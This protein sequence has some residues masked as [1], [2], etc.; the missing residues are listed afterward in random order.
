[1]NSVGMLT[2]TQVFIAVAGTACL[3]IG[4]GTGWSYGLKVAVLPCYWHTYHVL[5]GIALGLTVAWLSRTLYR[6]WYAYRLAADEYLR[7]VLT[8]LYSIDLIWLGIFPGVSE[9]F[10][11]RGVALPSLGMNFTALVITSVVFGALHMSS[12]R[13]LPYTIWAGI[14]G[15]CFGGLTLLT[16]NLLPVII[17][18]SLTNALSGWF[19][20]KAQGEAAS[21]E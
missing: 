14:V 18:H 7:I 12:W 19:W 10:L 2:R 6:Q 15:M 16:H 5:G 17:A 9:E 11:F 20:Q 21:A 13:H 1:M 8:P 4:I 3:L